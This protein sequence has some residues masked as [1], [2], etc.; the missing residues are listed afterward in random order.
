MAAEGEGSASSSAHSSSWNP[1]ESGTSSPCL[2]DSEGTESS[3][4]YLLQ[5]LRAP[6]PSDLARERA[7]RKNPPV[8]TKRGKGRCSDTPKS[9]TVGDRVKAYSGEHFTSSNNR[10]F[11]SACRE[12]VAL[13]KSV[14]EHHIAS[15]KHRRSKERAALRIAREKSIVKSLNAYDSRVHPVGESLPPDIRVRRVKV[16]QALLKTGIPLAKADCLREL[17]EEDSHALTSATNLS[18]LL[19]FILHDEFEKLKGEVQGH[20]VSIIFDGTTHVCE[21]MVML[22]RFVDD[23][24]TIRQRVCSL[25]LLA[26]SLRGEEVAQQIVSIIS[27]E[28]GIRSSLI[29]AA[30][31][32]RAAV[33]DVA[34]RTVKV[35]YSSLLDIGCFSHTLDHVGE[36]VKTPQLD[37][38]FK[39]W[40]SLFAHSP[41]AR[42]LW[43]TETGLTPP[44]YCATRWW[45]RYEVIKQ[46]HDAFGDVC[47]FISNPE[48]PATTTA[49][50]KDILNN[51]A[52]SRKLKIELAVTVDSMDPFVR[53]TYYLEGDG[54]LS[55][56]A[57]ECVQSLYAHIGV[58]DFKNTNA[59][60]RQLAGGNLQHEQQLQAYAS[61]CVDPAFDY[62]HAKFDNDLQTAMQVFKVA[63]L[64][65]PIK[66]GEL[67]PAAADLDDLSCVPFLDSALINDLKCE[68][69]TY[70]ATVEDVSDSIDPIRWWKTNQDKLPQW[71]SACKRMLLVQPSS[72]A[73]ERVFSLLQN[74]FSKGQT[75]ALQDYIQI[76][77]MLQYNRS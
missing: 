14:I 77:V 21:A 65:S 24:W 60:A 54:P 45:S 12:V 40:I 8:G 1:V 3:A 33:N 76:S 31:R 75:S 4:Q 64:F 53:A 11:C 19:P 67:K 35:V 71:A 72:A 36:R 16:V 66:I 48:L 68:L 26:K 58:R 34:M 52:N 57:Y 9:V 6:Q 25:K 29:V 22:L 23:Q 51:P 41:K 47:T 49:K 46:M 63:R 56:S 32:D 39:A 15:Q 61:G 43:R 17:L 37:L 74:S 55:L 30:S 20:P 62:F 27:Q 38:F 42:L 73:A 69:P 70:I 13:K 59:V 28:L 10:L 2:S 50:M 18:Q 44:S 7:L 5:R